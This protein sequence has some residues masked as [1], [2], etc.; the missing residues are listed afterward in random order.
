[1]K[2]S[3]ENHFY[4]IDQVKTG[5]QEAYLFIFESLYDSLLSYVFGLTN[6][7]QTSEDIV[8]GTFLKIWERRETLSIHSS[9]KNYFFRTCYNEFVNQYRG[10]T[11]NIPLSDELYTN[12][13]LEEEK[14]ESE[15]KEELYRQLQKAIDALPEKCKEIFLLH[16]LDGYKY[17]EIAEK[18]EISVKTVKNQLLKAYHKIR[19]DH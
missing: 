15:Y 9:I 16:K 17:Q 4:L 1:M 19:V 2:F 13:F 3:L 10:R 14:N 5:N 18:L 12:V 11:E 6:D 8:Q 7:L